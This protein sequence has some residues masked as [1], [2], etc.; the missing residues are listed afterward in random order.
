MG[1]TDFNFSP[2]II[3][4]SKANYSIDKGAKFT[5]NI[6]LDNSNNDYY[7]SILQKTQETPKDC[8]KQRISQKMM[9]EAA[10]TRI[11]ACNFS[12]M[13]QY[14]PGF[15]QLKCRNQKPQKMTHKQLVQLHQKKQMANRFARKT[16]ETVL[17]NTSGF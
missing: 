1:K 6:N 16:F 10:K 5:E 8:R 14:I 11:T 7:S 9:A 2:Q 12:P 4:R 3:G 13:K 17:M 15:D